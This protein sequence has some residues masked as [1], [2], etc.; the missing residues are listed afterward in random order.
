[1][2]NN[3]SVVWNVR[4]F[5]CCPFWQNTTTIHFKRLFRY[6]RLSVAVHAGCKAFP[7][8]AETVIGVNKNYDL[9]VPVVANNIFIYL[10]C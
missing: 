1:M 8:V 2:R 7:Y 4:Y 10:F 5:Y 6:C 9:V 3:T